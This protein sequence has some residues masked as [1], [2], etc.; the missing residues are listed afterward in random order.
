[1]GKSGCPNGPLR[2]KEIALCAGHKQKT[3]VGFFVFATEKAG[4]I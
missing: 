3:Q 4:E 1:M 2:E